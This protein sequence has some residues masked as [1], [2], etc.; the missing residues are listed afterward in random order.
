MSSIHWTIDELADRVA[1]ALA[2]A[3]PGEELVVPQSNG[4]VREVPDARTIRWYQTTGMVD[5]PVAM[6]GRTALYGPRHLAQIV[7]IKR[8]QAE[9][10]TLAEIQG[11]LAGMRDEALARLAA[12]PD[13][14]D[15]R[16]E[17]G[18]CR[19]EEPLASRF[20]TR[21]GE[22]KLAAKVAD[23][24]DTM[25]EDARDEPGVHHA[26]RLDEGVLLVLDGATTAPDTDDLS[27]IRSLTGA[28][29]RELRRRGLAPVIN[30]RRDDP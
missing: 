16:A 10:R 19:E 29:L 8:L 2:G 18:A 25:V 22:E 17:V 4:R 12:V 15:S 28:L 11:Q 23:C 3:E 26:I 21:A 5:R 14:E 27:A 9:G 6:R 13:V 24:A 30:P 20:W 1:A 7:A